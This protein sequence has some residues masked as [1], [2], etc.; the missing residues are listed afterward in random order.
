MFHKKHIVI[1]ALV[2]FF[3][4]VV[5]A[6]TGTYLYCTFTSYDV[7]SQAKKL[8]ADRYVDPLSDE[9]LEKMD[10]YAISAM[11]ASLEDP[12]SYYF[13]E[14]MFDSY[15]ENTKEEYVG[16]GI[17]VSF[18]AAT[19]QLIVITPTDGSP[20]QKA[21][22]LPGDVITKVDDL[23]ITQDSYND[24]VEYIRGEEAKEGTAVKIFVLR[25]G[26][27]KIFEVLRGIIPLETISY[28]MLDNNVGYIRI[29]EFKH[30]S[31]DDFKEAIEAIKKNDA[32]GLIIDLRSNPGGYAD[33]VLRMTDMLLPEGTIAYLEDNKG[34]REYFYS[35]KKHLGL[36]IAILVNE[37]TASA[38]EL[39]AGSTQ[40]HGV[41]KIV[42]KKTFG[43]A[44]GQT[45]FMLTEET[46]IYLTCAR[47]YTPKG[48]CIDK[49]GIVPDVEVDLP[50]EKKAKL[51]SLE[52]AE[53]DQLR[54]ALE[55]LYDEIRK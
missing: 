54:T 13:D 20:A 26:E 11:V 9:Q 22:I 1:T 24:V 5:F 51:A 34:E 25:D 3:A 40:A 41:A 18:D 38:A 10:D 4:T 53:D 2:T 33:S 42:G 7:V 14:K 44:V 19:K 39:M 21:G 55:T 29:S 17:N 16:I 31:V 45:P 50:D 27:E 12:Y 35:D 47:Y 6:V 23:V 52:V 28:K 49:K 36:P 46:A 43:K 32:Q 8:I 30:N 37:G 48:E 15:E